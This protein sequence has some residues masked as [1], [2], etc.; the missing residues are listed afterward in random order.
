M[1][2]TFIVCV[3]HNANFFSRLWILPGVRT[4]FLHFLN[5]MARLR[6]VQFK[7]TVTKD[8]LNVPVTIRAQLVHGF[9]GSTYGAS[10]YLPRHD[11]VNVYTY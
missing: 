6:L 11:Q 1:T 10:C 3:T 9:G 2:T 5:G 4:M 8:E 7:E